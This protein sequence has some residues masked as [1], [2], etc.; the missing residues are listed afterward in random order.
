MGAAR[1]DIFF[2]RAARARA[3]VVLF[4]GPH[5]DE[6]DH[7]ASLARSRGVAHVVLPGDPATLAAALDGG[8]VGG[9][10]RID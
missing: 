8:A 9:M 3:R 1:S 6:G 7:L 2:A 4:T 10:A 5:D